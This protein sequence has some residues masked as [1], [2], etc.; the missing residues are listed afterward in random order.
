MFKPENRAEVATWYRLTNNLK[1]INDITKPFHFPMPDMEDIVHFTR[2]SRYWSITDIKDAFFVV[3]MDVGSRDATTFTT[4]LGRWR[5]TVMPQGAKNSATF[6]AKIASETFSGIPKGRLI[7]FV[8][9]TTNHSRRFLQHWLTQQEMY[10][11]LRSKCLVAKV[12]KSHFLYP[13]AK[14]LGSIMSE[15]GRTPSTNHIEAILQMAPPRTQ[16]EVRHILGLVN[17]NREYLPNA[18]SYLAAFE[19]LLRTGVDVVEQWSKEIHGV[20]FESLKLAL[21]SAPCLLTIDTTKPFVIHVDASRIGRGLGAVLLQKNEKGHWRPVAYYSYKL[22]DGERTRCATELE[23]MALVYAVRHWARY[24]RVQEFTAIVD[25]HSLLYLVTQPAKTSNVRLLNWI[26]DLHNYRFNIRYRKGTKHMDADAVSR[27]LHYQDLDQHEALDTYDEDAENHRG[28]A[29][30]ED[31]MLV[32]HHIA[33]YQEQLRQQKEQFK[34]YQKM[35]EQGAYWRFVSSS[36]YLKMLNKQRLEDDEIE[37]PRPPEPKSQEETRDQN[38]WLAQQDS[39]ATAKEHEDLHIESDDDDMNST[40]SEYI[41][42]EDEHEKIQEEDD[43]EDDEDEVPKDV[44]Y[45]YAEN[46]PCFFPDP[47]P[48]LPTVKQKKPLDYTPPVTRAKSKQ[49][50]IKA[51]ALRV[52]LLRDN[53]P[54]KKAVRN[55]LSKDHLKPFDVEPIGD[56]E[57]RLDTEHPEVEPYKDLQWRIFIDPVQKRPYTVVLPYYDHEVNAVACYRRPLDDNPPHPWDNLPWPVEGNDGIAALVNEHQ[58]QRP[59]EKQTIRPEVPWPTNEREMF[60]LQ[61]LDPTLQPIIDRLLNTDE[62]RN[63]VYKFSKSKY[64]YLGSYQNEAGIALRVYDD[65]HD[66]GPEERSVLTDR[67]VV[68]RTLIRQVIEV[69][70]DQRAH[71]GAAGTDKT[72]SLRYWWPSHTA[73]VNS[74]V[75]SCQFCRYQKPNTQVATPPVLGYLTPSHPWEEVHVDLIGPLPRTSRGNAHIIVLKCALTGAVEIAPMKTK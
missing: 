20:A 3:Y 27:L 48:F 41:D 49:L 8:D 24:L 14:V 25:H 61:R 52:P 9:D 31:I 73:D 15:Y 43:D 26:S 4:P 12:S 59:D 74:Y 67:V 6:F 60:E 56:R 66:M 33:E 30:I 29:T 69:Y 68:P 21:T 13:T 10:D 2:G 47:D 46:I 28:P 19:D 54:A 7:N 34:D 71:P 64:L 45:M 62:P 23:A 32:H 39:E 55:K 5:F 57:V 58:T 50:E 51:G 36:D 63:A 44:A 72:I 75:H 37:M 70:H 1:P 40:I 65:K 35:A 38:E 22:K 11:A 18:K 53:I 16:A 17:F 42:T